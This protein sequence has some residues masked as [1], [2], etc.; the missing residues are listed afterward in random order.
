[1]TL[2]GH[3]H[4][5]SQGGYLKLKAESCHISKLRVQFYTWTIV[6]PW[7]CHLPI[8][9]SELMSVHL[10]LLGKINSCGKLFLCLYFIGTC[11]W[12]WIKLYD[13]EEQKASACHR[14]CPGEN[15]GAA[16]PFFF[17]WHQWL[18]HRLVWDPES[19]MELS[20]CYFQCNMHRAEMYQRLR[21]CSAKTDTSQSITV[22]KS[23]NLLVVLKK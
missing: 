15:C 3:S 17:P 9:I 16:V 19:G 20:Y 6:S 2:I 4:S 10:S 5:I 11:K 12:S 18:Q 1:M 21:H 13:S 22:V 8:I 14:S 7:S 23:S